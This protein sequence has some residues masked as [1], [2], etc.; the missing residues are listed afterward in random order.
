MKSSRVCNPS[1]LGRFAAAA[2]LALFVAP[3]AQAGNEPY[4]VWLRPE[5]GQ[6]FSFYDCG[7]LL[8][9]KLVSVK[10]AEEQREIGTVIL[11]GATKSGA[12]EWRGKL[13]NAKD[14]NVYDGVITLKS[15]NEL[16][17]KGCLWGV[18]C[19]GETWRRATASAT[20]ARAPDKAQDSGA[21][22]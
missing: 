19:K 5:A 22:E 12:K 14:G 3:A 2:L 18:L 7:G 10:N 11:R 15:A 8:C 13:Y 21:D 4:G 9:A 20:G 17:L 16:T 1:W 6:Q